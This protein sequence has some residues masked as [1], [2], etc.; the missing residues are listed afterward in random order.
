MIIRVML[1]K[2][3]DGNDD[4]NDDNDSNYSSYNDSYCIMIVMTITMMIQSHLPVVVAE[5]HHG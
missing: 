1:I 4:N 5:L 2:I 3:E